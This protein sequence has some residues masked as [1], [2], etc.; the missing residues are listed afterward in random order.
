MKKIAILILAMIIL[1][2]LVMATFWDTVFRGLGYEKMFL[3]M[4]NGKMLE[5]TT[6]NKLTIN[7]TD[8][9]SFLRK[10]GY[11][12][13]QIKVCIHN[14]LYSR[15]FSDGDKKFYKQIKEAGFVGKFQIYFRGKVYTLKQKGD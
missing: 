6:Y 8:F 10:K 14:H 9:F 4:N 13:S 12:V 2:S 1:C 11:D 5:Y 7:R 15:Q 3:R